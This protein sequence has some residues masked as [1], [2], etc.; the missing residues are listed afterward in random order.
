MVYIS[1]ILILILTPI[2]AKVALKFNIVDKP[3]N[4][5]K[6]HEKVT[7]YLGGLAIYFS[8][9]PIIYSNYY[10]FIFSFLIMGIG[11]I[12]DIKSISPKVRFLMELVV[13]FYTVYFFNFG[14]NSFEII[15]LSFAGVA[16]INA[17]NFVDGMDGVCTGTSLIALLFLAFLLK[18]FYFVYLAVPILGFL[19]YNFSPAKIFLGDAGSYY[20]G[21]ILFFASLNMKLVYGANGFIISLI[22]FSIFI[23]DM[24]FAVIRRFLVKKSIF[25]GDR[26]HIYD[27][28]RKRFNVS[29]KKTVLILY[30]FSI[31]FGLVGVI[32]WKNLYLGV[33]I[34][35]VM[36]IFFGVWFKLYKYDK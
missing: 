21:Y 29:I 28:V 23:I 3:D 11:L 15:L 26:G 9:I 13:C 19:I 12:D 18:D 32:A 7:P 34:S 2:I 36:I 30:S 1:L 4:N 10:L 20:L 33:I 24:L 27:G 31:T 8:S 22:V 14:Y 17:V 35:L 25:S 5:L 16:I 6:L